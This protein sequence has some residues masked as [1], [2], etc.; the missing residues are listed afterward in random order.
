MGDDASISDLYPDG[1]CCKAD[2]GTWFKICERVTQEW[3]LPKDRRIIFSTANRDLEASED[4]LPLISRFE[5][6]SE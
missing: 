3:A 4:W 6:E 5:R 1:L 2:G